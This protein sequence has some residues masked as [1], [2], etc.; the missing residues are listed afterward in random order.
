MKNIFLLTM[1][2]S[3]FL[4]SNVVFAKLVGSPARRDYDER[5]DAIET[6]ADGGLELASGNILVGD[7]GGSGNSVAMSGNVTISNA[8]VTALA[9]DSVDSD[10]IIANAVD[11]AELAA[12]A[13]T[14]TEI[15][16]SAITEADTITQGADGLHLKRIARATLD[17]VASSCVAG[18][19]SMGVSLPAFALI[20]RSYWFTVTQ[21]V[22]GGAGTV[23][24]EC[25]DS[26][27]IFAAADITGNADGS[28]VEGIQLG[29]AATMTGAI[30][31]T[32]VITAV[33]ATAEQTAGKLILIV[34]YQ[35][36]E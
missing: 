7:A 35:V 15:A 6:F 32:C 17:C 28:F 29:T 1:I 22:D 24:L 13:V 21:F 14:A 27:N 18:S 2:L 31:A 8:G 5:F 10:E 9:T 26:G 4:L 12:S 34:E 25:E 33:I 20:Q 16:A 30:A 36:I 19:V 3:S 11:T 23:A